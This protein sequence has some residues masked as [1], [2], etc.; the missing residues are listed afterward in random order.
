MRTTVSIDDN[1]LAAAKDRARSRG[2]SLGDVLE[3]G[4]RLLLTDAAP[5]E[6]FDPPTFKGTGVRP[7]VDLTSNRA[8]YD[9]LDEEEDWPIVRARE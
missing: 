5:T 7:G 9:L 3:D 8:I 6:P 1:L 2:E 4:L